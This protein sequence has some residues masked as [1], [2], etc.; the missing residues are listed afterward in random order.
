MKSNAILIWEPVNGLQTNLT[1]VSSRQTNPTNL[2]LTA[3]YTKPIHLANT[4]LYISLHPAVRRSASQRLAA[5]FGHFAGPSPASS[6]M[7]LLIFIILLLQPKSGGPQ[8]SWSLY[9]EGLLQVRGTKAGSIRFCF[10]F[11]LRSAGSRRWCLTRV[12]LRRGSGAL[13]TRDL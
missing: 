13:L 4:S 1:G 9:N 8:L 12:M 10:D 7:H 5:Q 6:Q 2:V 11:A 3:H